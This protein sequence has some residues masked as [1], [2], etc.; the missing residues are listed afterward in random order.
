[1]QNKKKPLWQKGKLGF[2]LV[3]VLVAIAILALLAVPL[4]QTMISS[5]QINSKSK[6][7]GVASDMS[8]TVIESMQAIQLGDVLTEVNGY[9]TDNVGNDLFDLNT[10][11]GYS[12]V[13]NALKGYEVSST[14]EVM[15]LC[16]QCHDRVNEKEYYHIGCS[17]VN[18]YSHCRRAM[19]LEKQH[20]SSRKAHNSGTRG[21]C[22]KQ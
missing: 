10:G 9:T 11:D 2:S 20:S 15:M 18:N 7:V 13:H 5:S 1:M 21:N 19:V 16:N 8:N 22:T 12:F 17:C 6:D 14:Y 4:A 3:E